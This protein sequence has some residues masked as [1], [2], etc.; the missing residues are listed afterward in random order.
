MIFNKSGAAVPTETSLGSMTDFRVFER[1]DLYLLTAAAASSGR[2]MGAPLTSQGAYVPPLE[3]QRELVNREVGWLTEN[4]NRQINELD[5]DMINAL[6][7]ILTHLD[8]VRA[9]TD[10]GGYLINID[11]KFTDQLD[12]AGGV[13]SAI[14]SAVCGTC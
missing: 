5:D 7:P 8:N 3:L 1:P 12:T 6:Y 11:F 9:L 14:E 13:E 4:L 2:E 10:R